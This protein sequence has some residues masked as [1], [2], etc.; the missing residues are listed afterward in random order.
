MWEPL[1]L[2]GVS[3]FGGGKHALETAIAIQKANQDVLVVRAFFDAEAWGVDLDEMAKCAGVNVTSDVRE[4]V[5]RSN[6]L[7]LCLGDLEIWDGSTGHAEGK[8]LMMAYIN[9]GLFRALREIN[10]MKPVDKIISVVSSRLLRW[11][12]GAKCAHLPDSQGCSL[13]YNSP[14]I[15][16]D[17]H[18]GERLV[19]IGAETM[20]ICETLERL[21]WTPDNTLLTMLNELSSEPSEDASC[22]MVSDGNDISGADPLCVT[23]VMLFEPPSREFVRFLSLWDRCAKAYVAANGAN[24]GQAVGHDDRR[25]DDG[26]GEMDKC[27]DELGEGTPI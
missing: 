11:V 9:D 4:G 27:A 18:S 17:V 15:G 12:N 10:A 21:Y 14:M 5:K 19:V 8:D 22:P 1:D 20:D 16:A 26:C 25:P 23:P 13:S 2:G 3:V 7:L 24:G 6:I